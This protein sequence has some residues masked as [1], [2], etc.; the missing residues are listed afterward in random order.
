MSLMPW[1][2]SMAGGLQDAV[3]PGAA[4]ALLEELTCS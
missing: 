1:L 2:H 4:G 3:L